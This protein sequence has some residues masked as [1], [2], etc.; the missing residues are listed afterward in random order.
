M[1]L[2]DLPDPI[3]PEEYLPDR[4]STTPGWIYSR[5]SVYPNQ[6]APP[7]PFDQFDE[8]SAF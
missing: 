4:P 6:P 5:D 8:A 3:I 7:F 2:G 1:D